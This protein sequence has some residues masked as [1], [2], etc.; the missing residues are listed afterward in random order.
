MN[1]HFPIHV[2]LSFEQYARDVVRCVVE[3]FKKGKRHGWHAALYG[4]GQIAC[5]GSFT[6]GRQH[7]LWAYFDEDGEHLLSVEFNAGVPERLNP[8]GAIARA[9]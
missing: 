7:G 2:Q 6:R 4:N 9:A 5:E 1:A 3:T 8:I